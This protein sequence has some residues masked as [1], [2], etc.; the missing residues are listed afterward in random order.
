ML[1]S[2]VE[3]ISISELERIVETGVPERTELEFKYML[4]PANNNHKD[5]FLKEITS[6][7][8]TTGGDLLIGIPDPDDGNLDEELNWITDYSQ[9]EFKL[10][11][12]DI[13]RT[14]VEP[15]ITS[16]TIQ[17]IENPEQ[18]GEF[19]AVVRVRKSMLS[20]HRVTRISGKPFIARNSAGTYPM[21]VDQ[22]REEFVEQYRLTDEIESFLADRISKIRAGDTPAPYEPGPSIVLHIVPTTAFSLKPEIDISP[23]ENEMVGLPLF[24][25]NSSSSPYGKSRRNIDGIVCSKDFYPDR[26][27]PDS[28]YI[29]IFRDGRIEAIHSFHMRKDWNDEN[30]IGITTLYEIFRDRLMDYT[31]F[32]FDRG[33]GTPIFLYISFID[34]KGYVLAKDQRRR[35][36]PLDR[37]VATLSSVTVESDDDMLS[38]VVRDLLQEVWYAFGEHGDIYER[39]GNPAKM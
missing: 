34:S 14:G 2:D 23:K 9:D 28:E 26:D 19:V 33:V 32:L 39:Y 11:W 15:Q 8:N 25:R 1:S 18:E 22:L 36:D 3:E 7:A 38:D 27:Q 29:Q 21:D 31:S 37:N 35:T 4:D 24:H 10:K 5:K 13:L 6:F 17:T 12:E 16:H 30:S 20:P